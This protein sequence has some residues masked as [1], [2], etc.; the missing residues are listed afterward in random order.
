MAAFLIIFD[1]PAI[2]CLSN[3]RQISEQVQIQHFLAIGLVEAL[4]VGVLIRLAR[5]IWGLS[6]YLIHEEK[7]SAEEVRGAVVDWLAFSNPDE[8]SGNACFNGGCGRPFNQD[9]YGGM[10]EGKL[11]I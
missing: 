6:N 4:D 10:E 2:R 7:H 5:S 1:H 9:G 8:Y 3:L 11:V